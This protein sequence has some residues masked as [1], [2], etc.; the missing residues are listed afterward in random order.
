MT[1]PTDLPVFAARAAAP[2][3]RPS[4]RSLAGTALAGPIVPELPASLEPAAAVTTLAEPDDAMA[5]ETLPGPPT[6]SGDFAAQLP[7]APQLPAAPGALQ[8]G[9]VGQETAAEVDYSTVQAMRLAVTETFRTRVPVGTTMRRETH[10][11]LIDEIIEDHIEDHAAALIE[12][13]GSRMDR[14]AREALHHA[15]VDALFGA[16]RLQPLLDLPGLENLEIEGYDNVWL[17]FADGRLERGPAVAD[18]DEA[19]IADL[20]QMAR[21]CATGEKNFSPATMKLRMALPDG[22]RLAA[23]AWLTPRP[24]ITVRKHRFIDTDL[25]EMKTLGAVDEPI[26]QFLA[27]AFRAG[28]S[29]IISGAPAAGKTTLARAVINALDPR[30]RIGT[31]ESQYELFMHRLPH[32]HQR[33]W[34]AEVQEGGEV[35]IDGRAQGRKSMYELLELALQKNVQRFIVGEIL[36]DEAAA[37]LEIFQA[38][39]G[40]LATIHAQSARDTVERLVTLITRARGNVGM[41]YAY[42]LVAQSVD[43]VVHLASI[44][45]TYLDGGRQHRFVDEVTVLQLGA[46]PSIPVQETKIFA[47]GPDGRGLATSLKPDWLA[48]LERHGF[49]AAWLDPVHS[50]WSAPLDLQIPYRRESA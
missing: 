13:G 47:P 8:A 46:E 43:I 2:A 23:E 17:E 35:N 39:K 27:A 49:D 11:Q 4:A 12:R 37:L 24:S 36:G 18:S 41:D 14:V 32:R 42:R 44:D 6:A 34:A 16:G 3:Q 22:S 5:P 31:I 1:S 50:R 48:D 15:I 9:G 26:S 20:Q 45:E 7:P 10:E 21:T 25:T 30:I 29:I 33:V 38:G 28:K 19:L 40:G